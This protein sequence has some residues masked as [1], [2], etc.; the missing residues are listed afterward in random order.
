MTPKSITNIPAGTH[1][2]LAG[3][4]YIK[5]A[6]LRKGVPICIDLEHGTPST[7]HPNTVV[8]GVEGGL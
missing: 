1:F 4:K 8:D 5:T 7:F 2:R 6:M 3:R